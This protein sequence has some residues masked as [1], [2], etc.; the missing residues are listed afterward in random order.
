MGEA[1]RTQAV[2][3][4]KVWI[5]DQENMGRKRS[6]WELSGE[7][8][9]KGTQRHGKLRCEP[10]NIYLQLQKNAQGERRGFICFESEF[11]IYP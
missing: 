7:N 1:G 6:H 3:F 10:S 11:Y 2:R 9:R 8:I 4:W 5:G